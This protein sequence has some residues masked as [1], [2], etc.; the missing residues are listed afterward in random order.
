MKAWRVILATSGLLLLAFGVFRLATEVPL[1][2]LIWIALWMA[3]AIIIH[4]GVL[5]P[6]VVGLGWLLRRH[7]PDRPRRYL[8]FALIMAALV[9]VVA[10]PMIFLRGSQPVVKAM[11][12]R[13]YG[14][15]LSLILG[16]VAVATLAVYAVRVA[17]P[18]SRSNPHRE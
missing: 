14:A 18:T 15:N 4:D 11:L 12:L 7:V 3:G 10:L 17:R 2:N 6:T 16:F 13:N 5:S 9:T 1:A 8:Q